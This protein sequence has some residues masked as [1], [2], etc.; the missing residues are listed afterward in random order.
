MAKKKSVEQLSKE[1]FDRERKAYDKRMEQA[2]QD[3]AKAAETTVEIQ[4]EETDEEPETS[5][6]QNTEGEQKS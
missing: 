2:K 4:P 1:F 3:A 5:E 6:E